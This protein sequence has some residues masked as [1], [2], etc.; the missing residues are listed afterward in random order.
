MA[1][2]G[3]DT[4]LSSPEK[5]V[6]YPIAGRVQFVILSRRIR[7]DSRRGEV[8]LLLDRLAK[9]DR[10]AEEALMP[11]V[12]I[13]LHRLAIARLRSERPGHTLQATALVHEAYMRMCKSKE[14]TFENRAHFFRLSAQLMRRILVDYARQRGAQKRTDE[15]TLHALE[16]A[17][18]VSAAQ[19]AEALDVDRLLDELAV[20]S[21]R[22][23]Q[24]VEM[25]FYAGLTEQE[26]AVA[27]GKNVRTIRRDWFMA[28]AWLHEQLKRS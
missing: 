8:T 7:M 9:G 11:R 21:P 4:L 20:L 1:E 17:I 28:R 15:T 24:V 10:S 22:Q 26:I 16:G 23:A 27:L 2:C 18:T 6:F 5:P 13:E 19:S 12:Y 3:H 25:R 14:L